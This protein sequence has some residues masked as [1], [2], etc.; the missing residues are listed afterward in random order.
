M[1]PT[2]FY[3]SVLS[4]IKVCASVLQHKLIKSIGVKCVTPDINVQ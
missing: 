3:E 2:D 1:V 4:H